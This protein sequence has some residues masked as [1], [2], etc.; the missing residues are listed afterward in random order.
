ML[1]FCALFISNKHHIGPECMPEVN[2]FDNWHS[3]LIQAVFLPWFLEVFM[4]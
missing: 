3:C 1:G 2:L 4:Q